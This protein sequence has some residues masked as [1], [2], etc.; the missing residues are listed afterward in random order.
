MKKKN[1]EDTRRIFIDWLSNNDL[2]NEFSKNFCY[3]NLS[4]WW[5]TTLYEK[6]NINSQLWY[7]N[8]N[9]TLLGK[10]NQVR[11]NNIYLVIGILKLIK[12]FLSSIF[13][14]I[15]IKIFYVEKKSLRENKKN[16]VYALFT[17]LIEYKDYY[18]DRQYGFYGLKNKENF[19]YFVDF[20]ESF[21]V[22]KNYFSFKKKLSKIPY[23]YYLS[24]K[25]VKLIE[26]IKIYLFC[27]KSLIKIFI[28]IKKKNYF[29]INK[30]D[31][32]KILEQLIIKS[33]FGS[34]QSQ[35][36]K[37]H[38]LSNCLNENKYKNFINCFD[39]HPEARCILYF[40]KSSNIK[41][42]VNIN[43]HSYSKNTLFSNFKKNEFS[44]NNSDCKTYSPYPDIFFCQGDKYFQLLK[45]TFKGNNN[46]FLIGSLKIELNKSHIKRKYQ[47]KK[48]NKKVLLIL[49]GINDYNSFI[50]VLNK[51]D[52]SK[53]EI[54][55]APHPLKKNKTIEEFKT[56]FKKK[57]T[58][59]KSMNKTKIINSCDYIVFG[60]TSLGLELSMMN[61][62][63][64]RVYDSEFVPTFDIDNEIPTAL[65][66]LAV[67]KFLMQKK[68][69]QKSKLI[70]KNYFYK[71]DKKA[72]QR[73]TSILNKF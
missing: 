73:L 31:C 57:Y 53:F 41:N 58:I 12:R 28:L 65:S 24:A 59:D 45:K 52:L 8:L 55:V 44:K 14:N 46:I 30:K 61:K 3:K 38:S 70:E 32:S 22:I 50:K 66:S 25:N 42:T 48:L 29:Y 71:Y 23:D 35:L 36:I 54:I 72:S 21:D 2:K 9:K 47:T 40:A 7:K 13:F 16:C 10:K 64:F 6:D 4:L 11:K 63:I 51:C 34:I 67:Q 56:N 26:I 17:N 27:F 39:F 19:V 18:I 5:L 69:K 62:N 1:W 60:D 33:F 49:C 15:F 20:N 68:I 37:G 43:H